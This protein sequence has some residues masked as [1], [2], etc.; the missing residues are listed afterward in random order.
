MSLLQCAQENGCNDES[1][2]KDCLDNASSLDDLTEC[3]PSCSDLFTTTT[4]CYSEC[5]PNCL[6]EDTIKYAACIEVYNCKD[7]C[8]TAVSQQAAD[9]AND[10]SAAISELEDGTISID[11]TSLDIDNIDTSNLPTCSDLESNF[12]SDVCTTA[13]C[14][15]YCVDEFEVVAECLI[16]DVLF[17]SL[18]GQDSSSC[19]VEC[20][21]SATVAASD[22][23]GDN[24]PGNNRQLQLPPLP[25]DGPPPVLEDI[26]PEG[27]LE[28]PPLP[29]ADGEKP[30]LPEGMPISLPI[31]D[32]CR[33]E[34]A[35]RF[36]Y[37]MTDDMMS[38]YMECFVGALPGGP[39]GGATTT[40]TSSSPE[41]SATTTST[42]TTSTSNAGDSETNKW[43]MILMVAT[44]VAMV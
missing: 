9:A 33:V 6:Y 23:I 15:A 36:A 5:L 13:N 4:N 25:G 42:T 10:A 26:L 14:C 44:L 43:S 18:L 30:Q 32:Q 38:A 20:G 7:D 37:G 31:F 12:E 34:L 24:L 1:V 16:N 8:N 40:S 11:F 35:S 19:D 27:A 29:F 22:V 2:L 21:E 17:E 41:G 39:A 3:C 28:P